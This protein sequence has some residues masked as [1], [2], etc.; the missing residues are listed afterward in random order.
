[1]KYWIALVAA[2][3]LNATAN[4]M[5]KFG[6]LRLKAA[7]HEVVHPSAALLIKA[8]ASNWVLIVGLGF[9]ASN[10]VLYTF[11]LK[12]IKISIAYPIMVAGGFAIIALVAWQF[13]HE[14]L[15]PIQWAGIILILVGVILV[16]RGVVTPAGS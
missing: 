12:E 5:M 9:F 10:V 6:I 8:L 4:L 3:V 15:T 16:A 2:L 14:A 7:T 13:L 1:M 11:A